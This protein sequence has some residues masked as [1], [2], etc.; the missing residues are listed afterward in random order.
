MFGHGVKLVSVR[1]LEGIEVLFLLRNTN[2]GGGSVNVVGGSSFCVDSG[3][4]LVYRD[5]RVQP[6]T[7]HTNKGSPI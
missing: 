1:A 6:T 7:I 4:K 3:V 2:D 5:G